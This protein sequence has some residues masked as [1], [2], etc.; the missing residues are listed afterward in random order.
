M[1]KFAFQGLWR[2]F[3]LSFITLSLLVITFVSFNLLVS[4][5]YLAAKLT[6][7]IEQRIDVS[8]YFAPEA[9]DEQIGGVKNYLD[10]L[11][12]VASVALVS[13]EEAVQLFRERHKDDPE[14]IS[15]LEELDKNPL[16]ATIVVKA[17]TISDYPAILSALDVPL[18]QQII[19]EK[20]FS[21]HRA[22]IEKIGR[23]TNK[24]RTG[25]MILSIIFILVVMMI[26]FN[27]VRMAIYSHRD[28][29]GIMKLVGA[30]NWFVRMPYVAESAVITIFA[31][32]ISICLTYVFLGFFEPSIARFLESTNVGLISYFNTNAL[33]IFGLEFILMA[34]LTGLSSL[35][36]V[37]KYLK[38]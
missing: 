12:G 19:Q 8:V 24:V 27:T 6:Q 17:K 36:A 25:S 3:W 9:T 5:N 22:L 23:W 7:N 35:T 21:D 33:R 16:G 38:K 14:I 31:I 4:I 11:P 37:G 2:N 29:I 26:V 13:R 15:A 20:D 1:L 32:I 28:E 30:S 18:Y 10:A 34:T